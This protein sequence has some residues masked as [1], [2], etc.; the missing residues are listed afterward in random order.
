M[1]LWALEIS[2][3]TYVYTFNF[4]MGTNAKLQVEFRLL[5]DVIDEYKN[6]VLC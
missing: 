3:W 5:I 6:I 1:R 2:C 4:T